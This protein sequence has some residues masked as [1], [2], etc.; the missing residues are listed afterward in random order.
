MSTT[1]PTTARARFRAKIREVSPRPSEVPKIPR[2]LVDENVLIQGGRQGRFLQVVVQDDG[3]AWFCR[4]VVPGRFD[5]YVI[6]YLPGDASAGQGWRVAFFSDT[7]LSVPRM[8][9]M[10]LEDLKRPQVK[11]MIRPY[12]RRRS[13]TSTKIPLVFRPLHIL[14]TRIKGV[15]R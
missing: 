2:R 14:L 11:K 1:K 10:F 3:Q 15:L 4:Y 13:I 5:E 8:I 7:V 9:Q 12:L 6:E